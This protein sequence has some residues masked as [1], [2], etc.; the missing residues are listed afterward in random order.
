MEVTLQVGIFETNTF[1]KLIMCMDDHLQAVFH[2]LV[3]YD[4]SYKL[5]SRPIGFYRKVCATMKRQKEL[6]EI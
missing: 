2:I 5:V 6:A 3:W 4:I 1:F